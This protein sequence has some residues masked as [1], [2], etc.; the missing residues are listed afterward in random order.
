[1]IE[2]SGSSKGGALLASIPAVSTHRL[3]PLPSACRHLT[4]DQRRAPQQ[5]IKPLSRPVPILPDV[6]GNSSGR[7]SS[8]R[9]V[10]M[11]PA[12]TRGN[13]RRGGQAANWDAMRMQCIGHA[14]V[15]PRW[16][17]PQALLQPRA[18]RRPT[19]R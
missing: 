18:W 8:I 2:N 15:Q 19:I 17:S 14:H 5:R 16:P 7:S 9:C 6:L 4:P 12:D 13:R 11:P 3:I 10:R 1:M